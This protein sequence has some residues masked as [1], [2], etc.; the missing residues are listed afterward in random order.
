MVPQTKITL[1]VIV[2]RRAAQRCVLQAPDDC[3]VRTSDLL[4]SVRPTSAS[5]ASCGAVTS[6][7][8]S[9]SSHSLI[10][11]T[12]RG[13]VGRPRAPHRSGCWPAVASVA[14]RGATLRS[15]GVPACDRRSASWCGPVF[16]HPLAIR[17]PASLFFITSIAALH[18]WLSTVPA[19]QGRC[20]SG[21]RH[22]HGPGSQPSASRRATVHP[23]RAWFGGAVSPRNTLPHLQRPQRAVQHLCLSLLSLPM[24]APLLHGPY[25]P[26]SKAALST[27]V[28]PLH[29][30]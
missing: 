7:R 19:V 28:V 22:R 18:S 9:L 25:C 12:I 16:G 26:R 20:L 3:S 1:H 15:F 10:V 24:G 29:L 27:I 2:T 23:V 30:C 11:H 8:T 17:R 5:A 13:L 14:G 4:P 21:L 6:A